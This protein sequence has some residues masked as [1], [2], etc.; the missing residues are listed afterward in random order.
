MLDSTQ[1][2]WLSHGVLAAILFAIIFIACGALWSVINIEDISPVDHLYNG[3]VVATW[4]NLASLFMGFSVGLTAFISV[5]DDEKTNCRLIGFGLTNFLIIALLWWGGHT[6][7]RDAKPPTL[8]EKVLEL[9]DR[10]T[11]KD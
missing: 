9:I 4:A 11:S 6:K 5:G 7:M 1:L 3:L 2:R 10:E 8:T